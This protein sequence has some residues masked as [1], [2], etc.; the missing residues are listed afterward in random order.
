[1][2]QIPRWPNDTPAEWR[3]THPKP[4]LTVSDRDLLNVKSIFTPQAPPE[5]AHITDI[6]A[7]MS[8]KS[9]D[10]DGIDCITKAFSDLET[11]QMQ[12]LQGR[13]RYSPSMARIASSRQSM[14]EEQSMS[15]EGT[16]VLRST[17]HSESGNQMGDEV[18]SMAEG[19]IVGQF[20][21]I[22]DASERDEGWEGSSPDADDTYSVMS[23]DD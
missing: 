18:V 1:M 20:P 2:A 9:T 10:G 17:Y 15:I 11:C 5:G 4:P 21:D 3:F 6:D 14:R 23:L 19:T 7:S 22:D 8:L 13:A 12:V 16:A